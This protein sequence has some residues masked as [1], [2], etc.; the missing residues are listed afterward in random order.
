MKPTQLAALAHERQSLLCVGLDP[1][2]EALPPHHR[3]NLSW[4]EG[5]LR[6]V[7]EAALPYAIAFK[8]NSA[9]YERWGA[10]GWSFLKALRQ[11]IPDQ[12]LTILDAKRG[13]IAHTNRAYAQAIF[14]ELNFTALTVHP[15][16]GWE[17]LRPFYERPEK[18]VFVLLRTTEAP[19]WQ[20]EV[21]S[22]IHAGKPID[23]AA[24]VGWVWGA[25]YAADVGVFRRRDTQSW[26]LMP[27][28]GAQGAALSTDTPIHPALLT[29][30][31]AILQAPQTLP[32]WAEMTAAYLP[33]V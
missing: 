17:S 11:A 9:F 18:W 3:W 30:S 19:P 22:P 8:F 28:L 5:Y 14:E 25:H 7:I 31:R 1:D 13:D 15:Y 24:T 10:E 16:L 26:L 27:G 6:E 33:K 23:S 20:A 32:R 12:Y 4:L 29:V 21:W 2:P